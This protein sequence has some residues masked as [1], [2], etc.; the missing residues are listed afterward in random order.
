MVDLPTSFAH[1]DLLGVNFL[2]RYHC[3]FYNIRV[4]ESSRVKFLETQVFTL[5]KILTE[6]LVTLLW[7]DLQKGA[8]NEKCLD[9]N[10]FVTKRKGTTFFS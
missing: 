9:S 8:M 10:N 7:N 6:N 2:L 1:L 5:Y 4:L 3:F